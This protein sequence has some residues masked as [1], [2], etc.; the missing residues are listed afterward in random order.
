MTRF[1]ANRVI[2][3]I[4]WN[5]LAFTCD[6]ITVLLERERVSDA[7]RQ[8]ERLFRLTKGWVAGVILW[9]LQMKEQSIQDEYAFEDPPE[10]VFSYFAGEIFGKAQEDMRDFLVQTSHLPFMT[11]S[12]V[13]ELIESPVPSLFELLRQKNFFVETRWSQTTIYQYHPLFHAYLKKTAEMILSPDR[14]HDL[15][16]RSARLLEKYALWE[17]AVHLY[18]RIHAH[19]QIASIVLAQAD[20]LVAEGRYRTLADWIRA[21]PEQMVRRY[22][23]LLYWRGVTC[24]IT[25][26]PEGL[27][28]CTSAYKA[29]A[30]DGNVAGQIRSWST[31]VESFIMMR[32][33]FVELDFWISEGERLGKAFQSIDDPDSAACFASSMLI[34]LLLRHQGHP[35]LPVWQERC[36]TLLDRCRSM[37]AMALLISG[38]FWSYHYLGDVGKAS[39]ME[40][41]LNAVLGQP[42]LPPFGR[43]M[44]HTLLALAAVGRGD[45]RQ[46]IS[47]VQYT[48]D[49]AKSNGIHIYD[50]MLI[51]FVVYTSLST[52]DLP[53]ARSYLKKL[54]LLL[55]PHALWDHA[56]YHFLLAWHH[57]ENEDT[58]SAWKDLCKARDFIETCGNPYTMASVKILQANLQLCG[59]EPTFAEKD[60][61]GILDNDRLVHNNIIKFV[62]YL[63]LADG[64]F[65]TQDLPNAVNHFRNALGIVQ[66]HGL[67]MPFPL[68]NRRIG[69]VVAQALNAGFS[70]EILYDLI[71]RWQLKAPSPELTG[72]R[73]PW[74]IKLFTFGG[75][76]MFKDQKLIMPS[77]KP[78]RK[79]FELLILLL[80]VKRPGIP[81]DTAAYRL[82]P[83]TEGDRAMQNLNTTLHRLRKL[84][85]DEEAI[86]INNGRLLLNP[87]KCWAD[88]WHFEWLE[89]RSSSRNISTASSHLLQGLRLYQGEF[90]PEHRDF[91]VAAVYAKTLQ[92]SWL[93]LIAK[94][95][96]LVKETDP[97]GF[98]DSL[99]QEIIV[100]EQRLALDLL[101]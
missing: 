20:K 9:L 42:G 52:G 24:L 25:D 2:T 44:I 53:M 16:E 87:Q 78:P 70:D 82:W 77:T 85:G 7:T 23:Y 65:T 33:G 43:I 50:H 101:E 17:D 15:C 26:P 14:F 55:A 83:E 48:L 66:K 75:L 68:V 74:P 94:A 89:Q 79:L 67:T 40:T 27:A 34:A 76:R 58:I 36:E 73:W 37:Q 61:I 11:S 29:F 6:E 62:T 8:A 98:A 56:Q 54:E 46:C 22:P 4:G 35:E 13:E 31:V 69:H 19:E 10:L 32:A 60:L 59:K 84:F 80:A 47:L 72:E 93:N 3:Q 86:L 1:L 30:A 96:A 90:A 12:M 49:I 99:R 92:R 38:L 64:A 21:V 51:A 88:C 100:A 5:D 18:A 81:R 71:D 39:I 95:R 97:E 41:R 45:H 91:H 57:I 63:T 28:L